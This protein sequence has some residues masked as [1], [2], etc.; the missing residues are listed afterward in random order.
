MPSRKCNSPRCRKY[1][2]Y[3]EVYCEEHKKEKNNEYNKQ[4]RNASDFDKEVSK[5]Y[6][7]ANWKKTRDIKI[8]R[9]PLCESCLRNGHVKQAEIIHHLK[10]VR[11]D[12]SKRFEIDNLESVCRSCHNQLHGSKKYY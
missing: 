5:F 7:S 3:R 8:T 2:D 11:D 9:D 4:I 6:K 1:I 12:W 10:E